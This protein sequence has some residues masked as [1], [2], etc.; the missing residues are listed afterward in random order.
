LSAGVAGD[1][2]DDA[3]EAF[4]NGFDAPEASSAEGGCFSFHGFG[5]GLEGG[6]QRGTED[7]G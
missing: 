2:G 3:G 1:D 5:F 7:R 4:V 6:D